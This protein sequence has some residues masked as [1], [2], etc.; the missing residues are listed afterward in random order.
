MTPPLI[1]GGQGR[2][3]TEVR[4]TARALVCYFLCAAVTIAAL[5]VI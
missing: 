3:A 2:T 5:L 4:S 1:A